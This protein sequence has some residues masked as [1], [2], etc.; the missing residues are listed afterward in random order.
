VIRY[1]GG[2]K[3]VGKQT[4]FFSAETRNY[5]SNVVLHAKVTVFQLGE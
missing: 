5:A 4:F 3:P 1:H 2:S